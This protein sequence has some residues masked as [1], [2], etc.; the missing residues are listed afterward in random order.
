[1]GSVIFPLKSLYQL[2]LLIITRNPENG[3]LRFLN[4]IRPAPSTHIS[5]PLVEVVGYTGNYFNT[6]H[7]AWRTP[8][9]NIESICTTAVTMLRTF[10]V[11]SC[12]L[13]LDG[14]SRLKSVDIVNYLRNKMVDISTKFI[15]LP[16]FLLRRYHLNPKSMPTVYTYPVISFPYNVSTNAIINHKNIV[17]FSTIPPYIIIRLVYRASLKACA[18]SGR[19]RY[20]LP[21]RIAL[22]FPARIQDHTVN[23]LT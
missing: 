10:S 17:S 21:V 5:N 6:V 8:S 16:Q 22:S 19:M 7:H 15:H 11:I 9:I 13:F 1:M 14:T 23:V 12:N 18:S 2:K 3:N 20:S 4:I